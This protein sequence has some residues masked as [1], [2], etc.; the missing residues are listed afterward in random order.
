MVRLKGFICERPI[1]TI[2]SLSSETVQPK[3][4][5]INLYDD[6]EK[7]SKSAKFPGAFS[8]STKPQVNDKSHFENIFQKL[9]KVVTPATSK[10]RSTQKEPPNKVT[11]FS[12]LNA[13]SDLGVSK[14]FAQ[15][16]CE[17]GNSQ[18]VRK[19]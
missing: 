14:G 4:S 9:Q 8:L 13:K 19:E 7:G 12:Q 2:S 16:A 15:S 10:L 6:T 5:G 18:T 3:S 11:K 17:D 1:P